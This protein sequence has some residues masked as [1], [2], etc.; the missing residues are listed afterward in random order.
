VR[1]PNPAFSHVHVPLASTFVISSK[2]NKQAYVEAAIESDLYRFV[3][4]VG[5]P[6]N[7]NI[8]KLIGAVGCVGQLSS[9]EILPF[10]CRPCPVKGKATPQRSY[11]GKID[12]GEHVEADSFAASVEE[13][14]LAKKNVGEADL[15][16]APKRNKRRSFGLAGSRFTAK[17]W[18]S[19]C[20][21]RHR[22]NWS[23]MHRLTRHHL[24]EPRILHGYPT[25]NFHARFN[26]GAV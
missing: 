23:R 25:D 17:A 2:K 13:R 4:K 10:V 26:A 8:K 20:R 11:D 18:R 22:W 16:R 9:S 24:P 19:A 15:V 7:R 3:V 21:Q 14:N 6:N 1:C 5:A 12:A